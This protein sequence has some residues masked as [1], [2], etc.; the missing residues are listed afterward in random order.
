[1]ATERLT[2]TGTTPPL[3]SRSDR[4]FLDV[5]G[6]KSSAP[7]ALRQA[8][9][10]GDVETFSVALQK[11]LAARMKRPRARTAEVRTPLLL[12]PFWSGLESGAS[13]S[14]AALA[15]LLHKAFEIEAR[16]K[17]LQTKKKATKPAGSRPAK[18]SR[19]V[20]EVCASLRDEGAPQ[21]WD[22]VAVLTLLCG[23]AHW[24]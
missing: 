9:S 2:L 20:I 19:Q 10:A 16:L 13:P 15:D 8:A 5:L 1:M 3:S 21:A 11:H 6:W 7:A 23:T 17:P 22:L 24:L 18:F 14:S 12:H 4:E